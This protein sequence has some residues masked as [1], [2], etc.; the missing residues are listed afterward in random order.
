MEIAIRKAKVNWEEVITRTFSARNSELYTLYL[1]GDVTINCN[2]KEFNFENGEAI[3]TLGCDYSYKDEKK[4]ETEL[5]FYYTKHMTLDDFKEKV[6]KGTIKLLKYVIREN[7][8]SLAK[9]ENPTSNK[10]AWLIKE[11]DIKTMNLL[12]ALKQIKKIKDEEACISL[13][14]RLQG[15]TAERINIIH[16]RWNEDFIKDKESPLKYVVKLLEQLENDAS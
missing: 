5:V 2:L 12:Q 16:A 14:D 6:I 15:I 13:T 3:F 10:Y 7:L 4:K 9:K 11:E 8:L 1:Y